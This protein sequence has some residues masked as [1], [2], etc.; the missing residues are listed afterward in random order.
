MSLKPL[1]SIMDLKL[2][3]KQSRPQH[4]RI[5]IDPA[6][7]AAIGHSKKKKKITKNARRPETFWGL[8][9]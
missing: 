5:P 9:Y 8:M 3:K 2:G 4:G 7:L 6:I 1:N